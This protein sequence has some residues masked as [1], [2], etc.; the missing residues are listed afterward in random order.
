MRG[1]IRLISH[2]WHGKSLSL[3][4]SRAQ[5]RAIL[6][7]GDEAAHEA[8]QLAHILSGTMMRSIHTAPENYTGEADYEIAATGVDLQDANPATVYNIDLE[9]ASGIGISFGSWVDYA[10]IEEEV[11]GHE[12]IEPAVFAVR[13]RSN[14]IMIKHFKIEG[15]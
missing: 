4:A 3:K 2:E 13:A 1:E 10:I 15:L 12:F 9:A 8:K 7:I 14:G 6:E 11:R 5:A